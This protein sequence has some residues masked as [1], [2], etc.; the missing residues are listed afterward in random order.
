MTDNTNCFHQESIGLPQT[1]A[2]NFEL[3]YFLEGLGI[4]SIQTIEIAAMAY[5]SNSLHILT[6]SICKF[7][8]HCTVH[9]MNFKLQVSKS[10]SYK[11]N[12]IYA[13]Y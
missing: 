12:N 6:V 4:L 9:V 7:Y 3:R 10:Y 13:A 1:I 2:C 11:A 8:A 5:H